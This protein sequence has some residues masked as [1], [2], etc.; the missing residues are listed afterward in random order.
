MASRKKQTTRTVLSAK[1]ISRIR[2]PLAA[3]DACRD[4]IARAKKGY[5]NMRREH[6]GIMAA[7]ADRFASSKKAWTQLCKRP[8]WN[9]AYGTRPQ[10]SS[11]KDALQFVIRYAEGAVSEQ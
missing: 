10:I 11:R 4:E 1:Q 5:R 2:N 8:F 7:T 6:L 3:L 9:K